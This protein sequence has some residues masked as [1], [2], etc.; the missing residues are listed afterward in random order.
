MN[1]TR[2]KV[3]PTE[4]AI[5]AINQFGPAAPNYTGV[6]LYQ[7]RL[8]GNSTYLPGLVNDAGGKNGTNGHS[9]ELAGFLNARIAP[10]VAGAYTRKTQNVVSRW[11]Y[12]LNNSTFPNLNFRNDFGGPSDIWLIY[13][14]DD[15][16]STDPTRPN[17]D[18]PDAGDNHGVEGGNVI[19]A[20]GHAEFVKRSSYLRSFFRGTDEYHPPLNP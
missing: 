1:C 20:D 19:F 13:D 16:L 9:Y 17:E 5:T 11:V 7:E 12:Q 6:V 8:H 2:E 4:V 14:A 15:R 18:Y 3:P 10:G